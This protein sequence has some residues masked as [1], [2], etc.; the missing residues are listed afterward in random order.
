MWQVRADPARGLDEG[1]AVTVVL[2]HP[3]RD[4]ENVGVEDDVLGRKA[5][6]LDKDVVGALGDGAFALQ[7][8][9]LARFVEGHDHDRGAVPAHGLGVCNKGCLALFERDRVHH[10]LSLQAL[11][12]SLDH[13]EFR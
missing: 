6:L 9:G 2:L 7:C 11:E 12:P 3:G 13:R 4:G 5:D 8:V 1:D 10:R